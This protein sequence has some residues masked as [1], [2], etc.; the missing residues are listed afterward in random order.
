M[1]IF[2]FSL[3][4]FH[5]TKKQF[6]WHY[7]LHCV[8][9]PKSQNCSAFKFQLR[10]FSCNWLPPLFFVIFFSIFGS[11]RFAFLLF[12]SLFILLIVLQNNNIDNNGKQTETKRMPGPWQTVSRSWAELGVLVKQMEK[13]SLEATE[14][15]VFLF[16]YSR[17]SAPFSVAFPVS[18]VRIR[19]GSVFFLASYFLCC[20]VFS[21][22]PVPPPAAYR[23]DSRRSTLGALPHTLLVVVGGLNTWNNY[24]VSKNCKPEEKTI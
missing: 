13:K 16:S 7:V 1:F 4:H 8:I 6:S 20:L 5:Q 10:F 18:W 9:K 11:C 14:N 23:N 3:I 17:R 12:I 2:L 21:F 19:F 15:W 24:K 22:A